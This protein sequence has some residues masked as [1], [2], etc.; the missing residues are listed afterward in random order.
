MGKQTNEQTIIFHKYAE[1]NSNYNARAMRIRN[2]FLGS[3]LLGA[4]TRMPNYVTRKIFLFV[5][6]MLTFSSRLKNDRNF[7]TFLVYVNRES[8]IQTYNVY[9]M[10][11]NSNR[12]ESIS[13]KSKRQMCENGCT[14]TGTMLKLDSGSYLLLQCENPSWK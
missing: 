6:Q 3:R 12:V 10:R 1:G 9:A 7:S 8:D 4:V 11:M 13:T 14:V 5:S 2:I